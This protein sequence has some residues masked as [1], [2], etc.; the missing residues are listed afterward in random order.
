MSGVTSD[1]PA[2]VSGTVDRQGR[3]LSA[4]PRLLSLQLG[5]GGE[6][7]GP[8][9]VPQLASL[10][11]LARTLGVVVSR[12]VIA[13][14]GDIDLDLWVRAQPE[15]DTVRL[16]IAGWAEREKVP[17]TPRHVAERAETLATL[18]NDGHWTTDAALRLKSLDS[19]LARLL[20]QDWLGQRFT[21]IVRLQP[22][23]DGDF[24]LLDA[25]FDHSAF[26]GQRVIVQSNQDVELWIHGSPA[27][28]AS[29]VVTG[30]SGGFR[31]ASV[32]HGLIADEAPIGGGDPHFVDRL[33]AALRTP[34]GRIIANA[35]EIAAQ[36]EGPIKPEYAGY[37]GDIAAAGRHLLGLV[38]DLSDLQ[39]VERPSFQIETERLDLADVARRAASLL[40]VRASD[41]KVRIDAPDGDEQLWVNA[42]FRR[43][44]QILVNLVGNAVRYSPEG[45]MVW[46]RVEQEGDI[47]ALVVADQGKGIATADQERIFGKFERV[48]QSEPGGSGLGLY[49]SRRLARAMGGDITVDSAPGFG[50]RFVLTLPSAAAPDGPG[51]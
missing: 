39:A 43:A 27:K 13:A 24:P 11:R 45:S 6:A 14:D 34:I 50:A 5:A 28:D 4:D 29:G 36:D 17:P 1:D 48:D 46:I 10:A 51:N 19:K 18:G 20:D 22:G 15:G 25:L 38:D 3:L 35:D 9:A 7:N 33:D 16:A 37:A 40:G 21:R 23:E 44:L 49:I 12:G 30:Y 26:S 47:A 8:L 41:S 31:W 42:E 32:P 2:A